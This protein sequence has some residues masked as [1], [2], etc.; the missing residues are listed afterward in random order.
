M[1]MKFSNQVAVVTGAG[2]GI[3]FEISRMLALQGASVLLNDMAVDRAQE[4][5]SK[6]RA[7]GGV[8]SGVGG[9]VGQVET[10]AEL[11][12]AAVGEFGRLDIAVANAGVSLTGDFFELT[13]ADF[14]RVVAV[15]LGGTF[16]LA[17]AAAR[18]MRQQGD[19]GRLLFL[20]SVMGNQAFPEGSL[21]GMTKRG[22]EMLAR[23]LG[24]TLAPYGITV[25]AIA[26]GATVT[27]RTL[28]D[29][30][31]YGSNWAKVTPTGKPAYPADVANA[32]LFF[33][34][35]ASGHVTGQTLLVDGGWTLTSPIP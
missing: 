34:S 28:R 8:S 19:G 18:Q 23:S 4:A 13:E 14:Q 26:P 6:I 1:P 21:Y 11:V 31:E 12:A 27:P 5:A 16:F 32:A 10:A 3:G 7:E 33:L 30:P 9:D 22:I 17:Q 15:N 20:S 29:D 24:V 35:P 2:E 25:N